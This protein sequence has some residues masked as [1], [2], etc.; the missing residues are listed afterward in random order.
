[1]NQSPYVTCLWP[2]LTQL[3]WRGRLVALLHAVAFAVVVNFYLFCRFVYPQWLPSGVLDFLFWFTLVTW[4]GLLIRDA[5]ALPV[6]FH[7]M[8]VTNDNSGS[9]TDAL[10]HAL[11]GQ[12]HE[13]EGLL[14]D[15][16]A[17]EPR[18]PPSLLLLASVYRRTH[19]LEA[20]NLLLR[21]I[22]NLEVADGWW[23]EI[24][25]EQDRVTCE[26][27]RRKGTIL[28]GNVATNSF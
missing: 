28:D 7:Q 26:I 4:I 10:C 25:A 16:L 3:W 18:D 24:Q 20:A 11:K 22:R 6:I 12:C 13:A 19:R 17:I 23:L 1:M 27:E 14:T 8:T 9:F 15:M 21:E 2:G 5:K